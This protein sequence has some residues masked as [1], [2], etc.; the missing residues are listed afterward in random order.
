MPATFTSVDVP[1]LTAGQ[2]AFRLDSGELIVVQIRRIDSKPEDA[3]VNMKVE[4]FRANDD[5]SIMSV[6]G[7]PQ[8]IPAH[9]HSMNMAALAEGQVVI[10]NEM[11]DAT[12]KAIERL[13]NHLAALK[14][15][16][17]IPVV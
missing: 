7:I 12:V 17:K 4:A 1:S 9:V 14:A 8:Q 13:R 3:Q 11:A 5:G 2:R 10:E 16:A 15:W 6:D